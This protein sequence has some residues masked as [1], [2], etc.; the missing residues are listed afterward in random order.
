MADLSGLSGISI[1]EVD[2]LNGEFSGSFIHPIAMPTVPVGIPPIS[3]AVTDKVAE[4][5][6][7]ITEIIVTLH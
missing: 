7:E 4:T 2:Y 3:D 5:A 1:P 6:K